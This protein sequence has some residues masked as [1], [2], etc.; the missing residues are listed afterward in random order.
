MRLNE[1]FLLFCG[2]ALCS[3]SRVG[4]L[5][6]STKCI[7]VVTLRWTRGRS[8]IPSCFMLQKSGLYSAVWHVRPMAH[9][10]IYFFCCL[11]GRN[12]G[13]EG[14]PG[15]QQVD[16]GENVEED[17]ESDTGMFGITSLVRTNY[18]CICCS[19]IF[20]WLNFEFPLFDIHIIY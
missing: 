14:G 3:A 19:S 4:L 15:Y 7:L 18:P 2:G 13:K 9:V 6:P 10:R 17:E 11:C 8:N 12:G 1:L 20:P 5:V 16:A